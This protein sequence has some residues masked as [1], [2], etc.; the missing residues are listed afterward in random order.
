MLT[1]SGLIPNV[2]WS[3]EHPHPEFASIAGYLSFYPA[4]LD[5]FF[6]DVRVQP[7]AGG[8]YG[9]WV[10]PELLGPFKG[11]PGTGAW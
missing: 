11:E 6:G 4:K 9:G 1:E 3:Y 8:F 7:Q 2:A 10:T 5:C